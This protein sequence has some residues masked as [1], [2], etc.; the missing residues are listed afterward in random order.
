MFGGEGESFHLG[1]EELHGGGVTF[2]SVKECLRKVAIS[3]GYL[4][5][6]LLKKISMN[7]YEEWS[8]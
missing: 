8:I 1:D 4:L 2:G 7:Y 6:V 5:C 3:L